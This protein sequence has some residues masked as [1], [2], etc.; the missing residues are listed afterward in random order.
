MWSTDNVYPHTQTYIEWARN[1]NM[2]GS[3]TNKSVCIEEKGKYIFLNE[4][5]KIQ[6]KIQVHKYT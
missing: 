5:K 6:F 1:V 4:L 3:M 2:C